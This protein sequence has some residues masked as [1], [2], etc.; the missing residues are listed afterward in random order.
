MLWLF[1]ILLLVLSLVLFRQVYRLRRLLSEMDEAVRSKRRLLSSETASSLKRL[2]ASE[3]LDSLNELIDSYKRAS[4]QTEGYSSQGQAMLAAIHEAVIVFNSE[5]IIEYANPS[6]ENLF[7]RG[8]P[9]QG[10]RLDGVFRSLSLLE[11]LE[12]ASKINR[13]EVRQI[14]IERDSKKLWFEGSCAAVKR[15]DAVEGES[16]LL[17]LHDI[18]ELKR[19]EDMRREFVANVSH[20]LRTPLTI[21]KGFAETLVDDEAT[22]NPEA[23]LR[24]TRKIVNNAERLHVLVEDL[25]SLSKLESRPEAV[26]AVEQPITPVF[27]EVAENYRS[28]LNE[29]TQRIDVL[30]D[31]AV[32]NFAFDRYQI[33]QVL[34]NLIE[35]I[36][37]YA[38]DFTRIGLEAQLDEESNRVR[39]SV[40]DD[41]PGIPEADVPHL[42]ERF[43]RVDKGRSREKGGTG[44]GLSIVKHI[45]Q[46]HGGEVYALSALGE[47]TRMVFE[48]PFH[49]IGPTS[50]TASAELISS[51]KER[52]P[53]SFIQE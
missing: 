39:C 22:L 21:I 15:L 33:L 24:F 7:S 10:L 16:T 42:F 51:E 14:S 45:I 25:M 48:L 20:E 31:P 46:L 3:L 53:V 18:T 35:N 12:D 38:P 30:V 28:R 19:L 13:A 49:A 44:L 27:E 4:K 32:G 36:F 40:V 8:R 34:D 50:G 37:R 6:A 43:Y 26:E 23:R 41:G 17:V 29:E 47:G 2:G 11:L 52:K 1:S 5:R 9:I